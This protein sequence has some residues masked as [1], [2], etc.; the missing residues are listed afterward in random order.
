MTSNSI[1][2]SVGSN[3]QISLGKKFAGKQVLLTECEDGTII[4]KPGKFIPDSEIWL[5]ANN[6]EEQIDRALQWLAT[7]KRKDNYD[8]I[9]DRLDNV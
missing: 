7:S 3:G 6:G 1:I 2:K 9:V 4:L 5:Y 8:E